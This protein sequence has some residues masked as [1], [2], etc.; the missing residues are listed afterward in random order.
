[1]YLK[2][3]L[4]NLSI[5]LNIKPNIKTTNDQ[6]QFKIQY[7]SPKKLYFGMFRQQKDFDIIVQLNTEHHRFSGQSSLG[8]GAKKL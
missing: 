8:I 2:F 7:I 6:N 3:K 1:M 5:L 4:N